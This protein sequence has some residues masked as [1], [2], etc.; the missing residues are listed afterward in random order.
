MLPLSKII[1]QYNNNYYIKYSGSTLSS[2]EMINTLSSVQRH[3]YN[4]CII[5]TV[6]KNDG[7][8]H[9]RKPERNSAVSTFN[10]KQTPSV[11][12][13]PFHVFTSLTD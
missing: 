3:F 5:E 7:L 4:K 13:K 12:V 1:N 8:D 9:L 11:T 6:V 2:P 10:N